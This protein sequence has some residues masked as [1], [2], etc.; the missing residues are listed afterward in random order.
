MK[1]FMKG[2]VKGFIIGAKNTLIILIGAFMVIFGY[3]NYQKELEE[4][5]KW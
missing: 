3:Y 2:S 5:I 1:Y 4:L